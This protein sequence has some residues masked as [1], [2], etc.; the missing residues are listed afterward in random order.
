MKTLTRI[1][2]VFVFI[3]ISSISYGWS[4][5]MSSPTGSSNCPTRSYYQSSYYGVTFTLS[6]ISDTYNYYV[7]LKIGGTI[8]YTSSTASTSSTNP[9]TVQIPNGN[10]CFNNKMEVQVIA[11][12]QSNS[13][14]NQSANA[15]VIVY[16][17]LS[18]TGCSSPNRSVINGT[19]NSGTSWTVGTIYN[20]TGCGAASQSVTY[21]RYKVEWNVTGS[22]SNYSISVVNELTRGYSG[23]MPNYQTPWAYAEITSSTN[24]YIYT[25]VYELKN[26]AGASIGWWPCQPSE[27]AVVYTLTQNP[28]PVISHFTQNPSVIYPGQTSVIECI[29]SQGNCCNVAYHW[30]H[31]YKPSDMSVSFSGNKAYV[32]NNHTALDKSDPNNLDMVG[33]FG[34]YCYV[35]NDYGTSSEGHYAPR[36]STNAGGCPWIFVRTDTS[37]YTEENNI[38]HRS[39]FSINEG[40]DITDYYKINSTP[41]IE[42]GKDQDRY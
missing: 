19:A 6:G 34:L 22:Y 42:N 30:R 20:Q 33:Q 32:T 26:S 1:S 3:L 37:E 13:S 36:F 11:W 5:N 23:S 10:V 24:A 21:K 2:L 7:N 17:N 39:E 18:Y 41:L 27:A 4:I 15:F 9:V 14:D 8:V 31:E 38:L 16:N 25:F 12:K 35:T 28:V 40:Y 29:L